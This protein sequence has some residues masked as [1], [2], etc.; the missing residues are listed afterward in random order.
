[1][2]PR[3]A[4]ALPELLGRD[5]LLD[6]PD[7]L[8]RVRGNGFDAV[9]LWHPWQVTRDD[10]PAVR[11]LLDAHGVR[12]ACVASPSYLHGEPTGDGRRLV[13]ASIDVAVE[14]GAE[15]VDTYFGHGGDDDATSVDTYARLVAPVL[16][17]AERAGVTVVIENEFDAF[18]HD[19][20]HTDVS[21]RP[22]SLLRLMEVVAHPR[23]GLN[24]DAANFY[25]AAADVREAAALLAP[26]VRYLH[27]KDVAEG[28][29]AGDG[30]HSYTDGDRAYRTCRLGAGAVPWPDVVAA[31]RGAGYAG[32]ATFEPH[33][34]AALLP[35]ELRL[36]A[37]AFRAMWE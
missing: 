24:L 28:A 22:K 15:V 36:A 2:T 9:E 37:A 27:V 12:A 10:A 21:R 1:V 29:A 16:D 7:A 30:W 14:L 23:L 11:R 33:C 5:S 35:D 18:G 8:D 3:L 25:C 4:V 31:L 20:G 17:R 34:D 13:E 6:H 19:P 32:W 26:Y